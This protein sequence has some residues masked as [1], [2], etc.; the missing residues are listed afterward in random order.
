[1][2]A[3]D[4]TTNRVLCVKRKF[5]E[6]EGPVRLPKRA[7]DPVQQHHSAQNEL[8]A[9]AMEKSSSPSRRDSP[10]GPPTFSRQ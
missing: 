9:T 5:N 6:D 7:F 10:L 4:T 8:I 3:I 1:M 2:A